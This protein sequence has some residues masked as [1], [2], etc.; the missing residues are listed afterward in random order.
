M[1]PISSVMLMLAATSQVVNFQPHNGRNLNVVTDLQSPVQIP[2][3][4]YDMISEASSMYAL[5]LSANE[6]KNLRAGYSIIMDSSRL[7]QIHSSFINKAKGDYQSYPMQGQE[8]QFWVFAPQHSSLSYDSGSVA[9][10]TK[11]VANVAL[12]RKISGNEM[13][14]LLAQSGSR[15]VGI[16]YNFGNRTCTVILN[17]GQFGIIYG[18]APKPMGLPLQ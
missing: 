11:S 4:N 8:G 15:S 3:G 1:L 2:I 17:L 13:S 10:N 6:K 14:D 9:Q 5:H 12:M 18:P 16:A 7:A